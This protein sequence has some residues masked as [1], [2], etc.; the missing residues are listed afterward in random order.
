LGKNPIEYWFILAK[1]RAETIETSANAT[2]EIRGCLPMARQ[3]SHV[4]V[5]PKEAGPQK[6][7]KPRDPVAS[8]ERD[9]A[10]N[11]IASHNYF[12]LDR[13]EAGVALRGTEVKSIREGQANLKDSYGLIKDGAAFLLNVHIGPYS[14]GNIAN[15]DSTRTRKLLLHRE[16]IRKLLSKTQ[17]KGHTLIPTRLFFRNG[18]VKCELAVA[19]G[20]QDWDKRETEKRHEADR[21]ARAAIN[22]NKH[23]MGR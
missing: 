5:Q 8:G 22:A 17:I 12:L 10:Q 14:H 18:R 21:E 13:F 2:I 23:R 19:K 7:A 4:I 16:E 9:A 1:P 15:H 6:A 20:K 11:R 3:T